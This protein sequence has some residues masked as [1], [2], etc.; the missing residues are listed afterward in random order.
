LQDLI[1]QNART[2]QGHNVN[3]DQAYNAMMSEDVWRR[4]AAEQ[5]DI[6]NLRSANASRYGSNQSAAAS[7]YGADRSA[8]ASM[9]G[10]GRSADASL[11][12]TKLAAERLAAD[13]AAQAAGY[14]TNIGDR[15]SAFGGYQEGHN[16]NVANWYNEGYNHAQQYPNQ[17]FTTYNQWTSPIHT[18]G[19]QAPV[20]QAN[21]AT[22]YDYASPFGGA[23][24]GAAGGVDLYNAGRG[25]YPGRP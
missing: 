16:Q 21:P 20:S 22:G 15:M 10:A 18:P 23:F 8:A 13:L 2:A 4:L 17:Q 7:M 9:Y 25:I 19:N 12:Q 1:A 6:A 24:T 14:Q 11:A 5:A 3:L